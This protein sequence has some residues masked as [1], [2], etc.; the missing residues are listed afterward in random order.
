MLPLSMSIFYDETLKS[1]SENIQIPSISQDQNHNDCHV[2]S[3][4]KYK[5]R[6]DQK[7]EIQQAQKP[8]NNEGDIFPDS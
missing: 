7:R 6:R 8:S 3:F 4:V 5:K 2:F 1:I